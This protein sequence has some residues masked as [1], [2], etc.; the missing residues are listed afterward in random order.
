MDPFLQ[1]HGVFFEKFSK[2]IGLTPISTEILGPPLNCLTE[3]MYLYRYSFFL[4]QKVTFV[5]S[6]KEN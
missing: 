2:N 4:D 3:C 1:F 5:Q 6:R